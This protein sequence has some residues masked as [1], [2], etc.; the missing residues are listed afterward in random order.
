MKRQHAAL[1]IVLASAVLLLSHGAGAQS[2][3]PSKTVKIVVPFPAG[4]INDVLA[5]IV[6]DKLQA[7]WGQS[8]IIENKT[9]A[10]GNIGADLAAQAEPNG[11]TLFI[12]PPGPLAIN[13][14]LYKQLSY[15]P[16]AF[17][18]ITVLGSIPNVIIVRPEI[19]VS[20]VKDL[21]AYAKAKGG[22]AN[23]GSQGNGATPH[24]N[25]VW[26]QNLTG[27]QLVHVPYRGEVLVVQ[28]MLGGHVDMFFGN[29]SA[30]LSQHREGKLKIIAVL[31]DK[32]STLLPDIPTATEAGLPGFVSTT[33]FAAAAPPKTSD[34]LAAEIAKAIIETLKL[35]DVQEKFRNIGLE[36]VGNTPA[37]MAAFVKSE[38]QRWREV[39]VKNAVTLD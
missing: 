33:W 29:I 9:G 6:A 35:A 4:G 11:Y 32:R 36:P 30:A 27:T 24:L 39:I 28:D 7:R 37:E 12:A 22:K 2:G 26:F 18:P 5:R 25:G 21:I 20:S 23:Y 16:E 34:A 17:V 3:F 10:G 13:H 31:D 8:V 1:G 14:S 15:K 19:G 38:A